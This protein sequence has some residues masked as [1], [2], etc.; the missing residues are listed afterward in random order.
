MLHCFFF[1]GGRMAGEDII[2]VRQRELKRLHVIRKVIEGTV[3]QREAADLLVSLTERQI[4]R[5]VRRI[6]DCK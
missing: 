1:Q 6:W 5:I 3:T 2:T 4:R